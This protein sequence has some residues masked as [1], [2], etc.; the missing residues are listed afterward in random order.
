MTQPATS[1]RVD[2]LP[3]LGTADRLAVSARCTE[4]VLTSTSAFFDWL[5]D[6]R[7]AHAQQVERIPFDRLSGWDFAPG[8]GDLRHRS[9]RFF[10]VHGLKVR[11][12]FGPV[13]EWEQPIIRQPEHG[14]L[15]FAVREFDGVLH[16]LVQAKSEPGNVGGMQLSPTVQAT[17]SNYTRVHGGS[18]VPLLD[19]FR[20]P[21]PGR[22]LADVLQSEQG[23]WFWRKRNRNM[24]VEVGPGVEAGEDFC[25]LTLGQLGALLSFPDLV[26]M[27][28][29]TVLACL[30][31]W[32]PHAGPDAGLH[33][34]REIRS[35]LTGQRAERQL[36]AERLPLQDL[37]GWH[38]TAD[39]ITHE[40]GRYFSIV[41]VHVGS[42]RRE[43]PAWSQPLLRPHGDGLAAL[44]VKRIGGVRH[45]LVNA[46]SEPGF[47]D[48]VELGPT[49]QCT[50]ANHAHLP[51]GD[52]PPHLDLVLGAPLAR[53]LF[54]T[55]LSEEGGRFHH[56]QSRYMI[57]EVDDAGPV[58][59]GDTFRWLTE[60]QLE[61]LLKYGGHLNVQARTLVAALRTVR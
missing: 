30:P 59:E 23:S 48:T 17:R 27:D 31:D 40:S 54:D 34:D 44:L 12:D 6:R 24:V 46:R 7:S 35:W 61:E 18:P 42:H 32:R 3:E 16:C 55:V 4:G 53:T 15:G 36:S 57:I 50:P 47:L 14:I 21:E 5:A 1:E 8:T 9:G 52:L 19:V 25:W 37:A 43:V 29:R 41:A 26:N 33:T 51:P 38:R 49:V 11:S 28:A 58:G 20:R 60:R 56:A 22:V 39:A 2:L 10:S 13:G 45:A